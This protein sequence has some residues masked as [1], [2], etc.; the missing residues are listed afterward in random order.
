MPIAQ[1]RIALVLT[2]AACQVIEVKTKK[3]I[4]YF[5]PIILTHGEHRLD[6]PT[7]A[8]AFPSEMFQAVNHTAT[9]YL[10][11]SFESGFKTILS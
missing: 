4:D 3:G 7:L 11:A 2:Y 10:V 9:T 1:P 6:A 8:T 5:T